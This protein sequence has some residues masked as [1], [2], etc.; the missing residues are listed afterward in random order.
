MIALLRVRST[1]PVIAFALAGCVI[2]SGPYVPYAGPHLSPTEC[3]RP[4]RAQE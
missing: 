4:G 3:P 2:G 1:L